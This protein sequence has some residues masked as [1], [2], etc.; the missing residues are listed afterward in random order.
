MNVCPANE[1][2]VLSDNALESSLEPLDGVVTA[3][4]VGT[5]DGGLRSPS[6]GHS[7][8][9]SA[10][11]GVEIHAV[12]TNRRVVLDA[13][14]DVFGDAEAE[15]AGLAEVLAAQFVFLD[16]E[17][18]LEDFL[19]LGSSDCDVHGDLFVTSDTERSDGVAGLACGKGEIL[20]AK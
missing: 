6:P 16:L 8:T 19:R 3:D 9:G 12:D 14:V 17:A 4:L 10:H 2:D 18:S 11:A 5:T 15:V 13:Q 20:L 7:G 1:K